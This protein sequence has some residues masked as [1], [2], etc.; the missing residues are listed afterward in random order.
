MLI[1]V[2]Q[3]VTWI[4][5]TVC[6]KVEAILAAMF[7]SGLCG[8]VLMVVPIYVS[9]ICQDSIRGRM[10]AGTMIFYYIGMLVSYLMGGYLK[11]DIMNYVC[12]S[13]TVLGVVL[14]SF[15]KESPIHLIRKGHE[16]ETARAIAFYRGTSIN[17]KLVKE[18]LQV[19]RRALNPD[20]C[21]ITPEEEKLKP[22]LKENPKVSWWQFLKKSRSTRRALFMIVV[23]NTMAIFQGLIV[24]Q[25]YAQPL[26]AEAVPSMSSTICS[27]IFTLVTITSGFVGVFLVDW[28]GR[29]LLMIYASFCTGVCCVILGT[30]IQ[31]H[32]GPHWVTAMFMCLFSLTNKCGAGTVPQV[33]IAE[34]FLPEIKS[35]A[36]M[37]VYECSFVCAFIVLFIFN[38]LVATIGLGPVFYFFAVACFLSAIF[39]IFFL[40]ETKGLTVDVIQSLFVKRTVRR[41]YMVDTETIF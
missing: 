26:F 19:L 32:W 17:S 16:N 9:E 21:D 4:V 10:T 36:S 22:D 25:V 37:I 24:A 18:E 40:P 5:K 15:L 27:V 29:R 11:Y 3:V 35:V 30:Q 39:S 6:Y 13:M 23:L 2:L 7:L 20:L 33:L 14:V 41:R 12:L 38:P 34:I 31:L 28:A 8:G 1:S